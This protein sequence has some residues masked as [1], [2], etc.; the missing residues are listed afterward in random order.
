MAACSMCNAPTSLAE[1]TLYTIEELRQMVARGFQPDEAVVAKA[2][3]AGWTR[4]QVLTLWR[5]KLK[6]SPESTR[7]TTGQRT[8]GYLPP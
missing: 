4:D 8:L 5:R 6:S 2:T 7:P 3:A 1:G